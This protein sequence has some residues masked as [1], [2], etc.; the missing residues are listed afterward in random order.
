MMRTELPFG[1]RTFQ[2]IQS[3]QAGR[4]HSWQN[5]SLNQ[6]DLEFHRSVPLSGM[7]DRLAYRLEPQPTEH[8]IDL[9]RV[10]TGFEPIHWA[11]IE[12]VVPPDS[13]TSA[14]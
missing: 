9:V 1:L 7:L 6:I 5:Q 14:Y 12:R 4:V 3:H 11:S 13:A 10:A 2:S 8:P